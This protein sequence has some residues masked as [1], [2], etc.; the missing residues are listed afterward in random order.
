MPTSTEGNTT[1]GG[2]K[3]VEIASEIGEYC[4]KLYADLGAEVLLVEPLNGS[5]TRS[6]APFFGDVVGPVTSIPFSYFNAGKESVALD[7]D[8]AVGRQH[9]LDLLRDAD[10]LIEAMAPGRLAALGVTREVLSNLNPRLVVVSITPF[11]QS[12]PYVD[13]Q[14]DDLTLLSLGGLLT[15]GG[16]ADGAPTAIYGNQAYLAGAQFAAV[17]SMAAILAAEASGIGDDIDVSI[18]ESVVMGLENAAQVY[19][20]EGKLRH[21]IGGTQ[22]VASNGQFPCKDGYFYLFAAGLASIRFW[23]LAVAW[24]QEEQVAGSEQFNE[25]RW[26]DRV[27]LATD[28]AKQLFFDVFAP[29]TRTKTK[30]ELFKACRE[31]RIPAGAVAAPRDVLAD[32]QSKHRGFIVSVDDAHLGK[33]VTCPGA[34]YQLSETPWRIGGP[35]PRV[36]EHTQAALSNTGSRKQVSTAKAHSAPRRRPLDGVRIIDFAW[37]GAGSY[38]TKILGDLGAE[39]VKIESTKK[40]DDLRLSAPYKDGKPGVNRSGYFADRNTSKR[41]LLLNVKTE[42]GLAIARQLLADCDVVANNFSPGVMEKMGLGYASL[43]VRNPKIVYLGMSSRGS[44]G[45]EADTVGYGLTLAALA[46]IHFLSG[47]PDREP[48]GTGTHYPDHIP[49]PCHAA[50]AL[51]AALRFQRKAGRGQAIDLAQTEP[52]TA[53]I[54]PAII[55]QSFNGRETQRSGNRNNVYAPRGVFRT[56]G[57]DRWIA[58]SVRN[59]RE[60]NAFVDE[61][62]SDGLRN[63]AWASAA[64]R[65]A[66]QD[67]LESAIAEAV[68][69]RDGYELMSR[70]QAV[71]VAAGVTQTAGD[72]VDRD[73]QMKHREHWRWLDHAEMGLA[74][75]NGQPFKFGAVDVSPR[76]AA[77]LLGEHTDQVC[78]ELLGYSAEKIAELKRADVLV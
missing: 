11:G 8:A 64:G 29:F 66:D 7:L 57:S 9:L 31:R 41:S 19:Q 72:L 37:I 54:G 27:F 36:G 17:S 63:P 22:T 5:P 68:A 44:S 23:M 69:G 14:A 60:W 15:M 1:L 56:E 21:R 62:G 75:H 10:L 38:T 70:L 67:A 18:H 40:V 4:G 71:G 35:V 28:E 51:L 26:Q 24:L 43:S 2:L 25:P 16:Y 42:Q 58:I 20:L 48:V 76:S 13:F 46:G 47:E 65:L 33:A 45:P 30:A 73:P 52:T 50:F 12:G 61:L 77:P 34:P 55:E 53:L 39:V 32:P 6:R 74:M 49:N 78:E 59:D 3:V